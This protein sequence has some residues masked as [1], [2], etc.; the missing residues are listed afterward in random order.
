ML[1][2]TRGTRSQRQP[3]RKARQPRLL[4]SVYLQRSGNVD[5]IIVFF[6][7][8]KIYASCTLPH[9]SLSLASQLLARS[10]PLPASLDALSRG[11]HSC[12]ICAAVCDCARHD[13]NIHKVSVCTTKQLAPYC[14]SLVNPQ[15]SSFKP[16]QP[17][18]K[19]SRRDAIPSRPGGRQSF[20]HCS[21]CY[22]RH[23]SCCS[24]CVGVSL[25]C[26]ISRAR[27]KS[28]AS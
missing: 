2:N 6:F 22:R 1:P 26:K 15:S 20:I 5:C 19:T 21:T 14:A 17:A 11:S 8:C 24:D 12:H 9:F 13:K 28:I 23:Q 4:A 3:A 16:L 25:H 27:A 7:S 10:R 18:S